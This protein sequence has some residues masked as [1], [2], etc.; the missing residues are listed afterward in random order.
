MEKIKQEYMFGA[1]STELASK[2]KIKPQRIRTRASREGWITP[3]NLDQKVDE[4]LKEIDKAEAAGD[5]S[6]KEAEKKK[7]TI[8]EF[9]ENLHER[10]EEHKVAIDGL[11]KKMLESVKDRPPKIKTVRDLDTLDRIARRNLD[12]DDKGNDAMINLNV[13]G[14]AVNVEDT[15]VKK[16]EG[17]EVYDL[18]EVEK[19]FEEMNNPKP[20]TEDEND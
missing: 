1:T 7:Q 11:A 15:S 20:D 18:E 19:R 9:R 13:L 16:V 3:R 14:G 6:H 12:M 8:E 17:G 4:R 2:Y 10:Q 5:I